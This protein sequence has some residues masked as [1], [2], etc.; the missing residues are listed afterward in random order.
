[1]MRALLAAPAC[2]FDFSSCP[3][4]PSLLSRSAGPSFA[5]LSCSL[6]LAHLCSPP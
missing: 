6:L 5:C 1:M 3:S 2:F 4:C